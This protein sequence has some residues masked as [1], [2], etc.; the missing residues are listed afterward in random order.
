MRPS[1]LRF[2]DHRDYPL[3]YVDDEPDNLRIFELTF[4]RDFKILTASSA[5]EGLEALNQN[6]I[7]VVLS[8]HRMPG[9]TGVE[10]LARVRAVDPN[11]IRM[12]VT[13]YGDAET[14]GTAINDGSIYRYVPKP[15]D[16]DD[17]RLTIRRGIEAYALDRER[18]QLIRELTQ[19]D[20]LSRDLHRELEGGR[21]VSRLLG[22]LT[23]EIDFDAAALLLY[24]PT[25]DRLLWEGI[26]PADEVAD[27]VARLEIRRDNAREFLEDLELGNKPVL[28][29]DQMEEHARVL[30]DWLTEVSAEEILVVPL[31]G[32][33]GLLG[34]IAIDNRRGGGRLSQ[35]DQVLL[36]GIA[37]QAVIA[38]ENA[39]TMEG[40]RAAE[41][42]EGEIAR[43]LLT[44]AVAMSLSREL[45]PPLSTLERFVAEA[46]V[47]REDAADSDFWQ[48]R[49]REVRDD[50]AALRGVVTA[51]SKAAPG[52]PTERRGEVDL[53]ALLT[54]CVERAG[55]GFEQAGVALELAK[56]PSD[57]RVVGLRSE[58]DQVFTSLLDNALAATDSGGRV[59]VG[60]ERCG[61]EAGDTV[62]V[63]VEDSGRGIPEADLDRIFDPFFT[64]RMERNGRGMGL[65][66]CRQIVESHGGSIEVQSRPREGTRFRV[67]L[68]VKP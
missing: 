60:V 23:E 12:L 27:A 65:T 59:R 29:A 20:Y 13:A 28:R 10:F 66:M 34:A 39:R 47:R 36:D 63:H 8:D 61:S 11:T 57:L 33:N 52:D 40:L 56:P 16:P 54:R 19:L 14:L 7:A 30:R 31:N 45:E 26:E 3:L 67:L 53:S 17:L 1:P 55:R 9:M 15:W 38:L 42:S 32:S 5:E 25:G 22:A 37:N 50:L 49:H 43:P 41:G 44:G 21:V 6:P 58:L 2:I 24:D 46:P 51:M 64:T 4:R 68:P 35:D 18:D 48:E 62:A